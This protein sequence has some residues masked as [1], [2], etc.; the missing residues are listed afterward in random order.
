[1]ISSIFVAFVLLDALLLWAVIYGRGRWQLKLAAFVVVL[2]FNFVAISSLASYRGW[3]TTD[4][5]P[6]DALFISGVVNE[7]EPGS[8]DRGSIYLWLVP[9]HRSHGL[10]GYSANADEP[11]SYRLAYSEALYKAVV[12]AQG[13]QKHGRPAVLHS[14]KPGK[15]RG[16]QP[17]RGNALQSG[18]RAY[19][20]PPPKLPTK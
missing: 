8:S 4:A 10:L 3:P 5:P 2:A 20:L 17:G 6:K 19:R 14:G 1:M 11:R 12:K 18:Y 16:Q 15:Q 9:L 13:I 7:P